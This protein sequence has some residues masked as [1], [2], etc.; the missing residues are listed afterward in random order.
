MRR[1]VKISHTPLRQQRRLCASTPRL[2]VALR[3]ISSDLSA[4]NPP[5]SIVVEMMF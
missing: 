5:G 1:E 3:R 2:L 4:W